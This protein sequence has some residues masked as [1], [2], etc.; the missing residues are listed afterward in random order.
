MKITKNKTKK[1]S[2]STSA[3]QRFMLQLVT[4]YSVFLII[5]L[6]LSL[7]L[8]FSTIQNTKEQFLQQSQTVLKNS[9]Q[10][11]DKN[12]QIMEMFARQLLQNQDF[13]TMSEGTDITAQEFRSSGRALKNYLSTNILPDAL[14]PLQDYFI[15]FEN[16]GQVLSPNIFTARNMFYDGIK[17]YESA[18][19]PSWVSILLDEDSRWE[20]YSMDPWYYTHTDHYYWYIIDFDDLSYRSSNATMNFIIDEQKFSEV[21][22]NVEFHDGSYIICCNENGEIMFSLNSW[23]PAN[24]QHTLPLYQSLARISALEFDEDYAD[25]RENGTKMVV[26]RTYSTENGWTYYLVQPESAAYAS[27]SGFRYIYLCALLVA[28][29][30]GAC[31]IYFL[32]RKNME[33]ITELGAELQVVTQ[34]KS[35]LQEVVDKQKPIITD[36]Y[37]RQLMNGTVSSED[38]TLYIKE[39]LS[40]PSEESAYNVLY[41]VAYNNSENAGGSTSSNTLDPED[42]ESIMDATLKT[43]FGEPLYCYSPGDRTYALLLSCPKAESERL[44][45]KAQEIVVKLHEYLLDTYG[46]WMFAGIGHTT[47]NLMNVW[48]AYQ[49]AAEA[50]SYTTKNYIFYPYEIIKKDSNAFYY[51]PELSTKLIHFITSGSKAQVL[52][53]FAL[54]HQ[55]NIEDRSLPINLL[56]FL[57]QDIRN[58]LLKARFSLPAGTDKAAAAAL[59]ERFGEHLSFKLCE[60]IALSLCELFQSDTKDTDLSVAIEKYIKRNYKDP[61]LCLNKISDEFQISESYFSHMFKEKTGVNFSTYLESI[62]ISEAARLIQDTD[63]NLSELYVEVGYNNPA[64]FRRVFKKTYGVTPSAMRENASNR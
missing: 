48:E 60:D 56:Q 46:I 2:T 7:Y 21:F 57:M 31:F 4:S 1:I 51:P 32:V 30:G 18:N 49:Q 13:W 33:P 55:E 44:I 41:A 24:E 8:Y 20:M 39:Y 16:S 29:A 15:Y 19:Y 34:E 45:M 61:S 11:V 35:Q 53:L 38:E 58:T 17:K 5:I 22:T 52:E 64:T 27:L 50:V 25:Y 9:V 43:Y 14:L 37:I 23:D 10:V 3:D 47:D 6:F 42:L 62:R 59:D 12:F 63:I 36:S 28:I 40:L 54:I 26:N